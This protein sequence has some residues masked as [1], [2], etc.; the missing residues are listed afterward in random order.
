MSV[1]MPTHLRLQRRKALWVTHF[2]DRADF[3]PFKLVVTECEDLQ[4]R[5]SLESPRKRRRRG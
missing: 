1:R 4:Q 3:T 2:A 5:E